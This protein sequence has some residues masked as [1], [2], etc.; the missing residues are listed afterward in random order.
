M[1]SASQGIVRGGAT[2]MFR[3]CGALCAVSVKVVSCGFRETEFHSGVNN[4][5]DGS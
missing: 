4:V 5:V 1:Y 3:Q 2:A